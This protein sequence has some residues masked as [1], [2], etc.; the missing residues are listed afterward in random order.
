MNLKLIAPL[1]LV[2]VIAGCPPMAYETTPR[3]TTRDVSITTVPAGAEVVFSNGQSFTSPCTT[4]IKHHKVMKVTVS[5]E[6][7]QTLTVERTPSGAEALR[8]DESQPAQP[9]RGAISLTCE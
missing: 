3:Y 7:C 1:A 2:L 8:L 6:G 4:K 5:K 9:W